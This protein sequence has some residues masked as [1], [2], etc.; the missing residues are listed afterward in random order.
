MENKTKVIVGAV[1]GALALGTS[2]GHD[3][4]ETPDT[5]LKEVTQI[6]NVTIDAS[7]EQLAA[8]Y[9]EGS[10]SVEPVVCAEAD[11][12][13]FDMV[14]EHAQENCEAEAYD[15]D[16]DETELI[17][18]NIAFEIDALNMAENA[19]EALGVEYIDDEDLF[20]TGVLDDFRDDDV[21]YIRIDTDDTNVTVT[22]YEDKE[23]DVI[24]EAKLK[25][26]DGDDK[27]TVDAVFEVRVDEDG[28]KIV[29]V[30]LSE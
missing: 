10:A 7:A 17:V 6:R 8:A 1:L 25:V 2:I 16:E 14:L 13:D 9:D 29:D 3:I 24:V 30:T 15:V 28:A 18:E 12:S 20:N 27:K 5:I 26:R 22:D 23:A 21:V 11:T 4:L 19:V